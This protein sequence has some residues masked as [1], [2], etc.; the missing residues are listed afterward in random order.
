MDIL[1]SDDPQF[2][3]V[4]YK[5]LSDNVREWQQEIS[6]IV[7]ERLP[8]SLDL[9]T[10]VVFQNV[11]DE[12]GYAQGTAV[13]TDPATGQSIG[14]PLVV[15]SWHLAP[16]DLFIKDKKVFPLTDT[17]LAKAMFQ[18]S[19]GAGLA[20]QKPPP[21]MADDVFSDARN[22]PL[23]GKYSYSAPF[24]MLKHIEG[25]LGAEDI[26]LLKE[27]VAK[28]PGLL[29]SYHRR[30]TFDV[31][32]KYAAAQPNDQDRI[33]RDRT[34]ALFTVKKDGP[35]AYRLYSAPDEVYDPV[36]V[37]TDRQGLKDLLDMRKSELWDTQVDPLANLD[38]YGHFTL[39]PPKPVY[40]LPV[41]GPSGN[42]VD[43]SGSYGADL[44]PHRN[45]W[46][47]DPLQDDRVVREIGSFGRY[48]VRDRDGVLAK[49][50]VVPNVVNFDGKPLP[51]KLFLGKALAAIQGR[52]AGIPLPDD[53]DVNLEED[54]PDTGKIGTLVYREG[55]RVLATAPFQVTSVTVYK[56]L[57][58]LGVVD[59]KGNPANLIMSPNVD[60]VVK[61]TDQNPELGPLMGPKSNYL[62]SA[63]LR[64]IRM[65]RLCPV[66]ESAEDFKKVILEHM[67]QNPVKVAAS[68][69]K[70][71]FRNSQIAKYAK[72]TQGVRK[73]A[74]AGGV[75]KAA[76]DFNAL[77]RVEAEFLLRSWGLEQEKTAA[78]L[79]GVKDRIFL[80]VHGLRMPPLPGVVKTASPAFKK[81][82]TSIKSPI[83]DVVKIAASI[84]DAQ[85]VDSILGLGFVNEQNTS[86]FASAVPMLWE[87]VHMLAKLLLASRLG[88]DDI[89]E[90][91]ARSALEHLQRIIDGLK[92]LQMK[93][94][95][96]KQAS[97]TRS[98]ARTSHLGG[99][100]MGGLSPVGVAR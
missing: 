47:F 57:K 23:G 89:P 31:L 11:D 8:D 3:R 60:G 12:K 30:G 48:A 34:M 18:G 27:A 26:R 97:V 65:P 51:T 81:F 86:R 49:G 95:Q 52:V 22:P 1:F 41:D 94:S 92:R 64:F 82:V 7:A 14:I 13:A 78:L 24:S 35:D 98:K 80:E 32:N 75:R 37:A 96:E 73:H 53:A 44:G 16:L 83:E 39:E 25:T 29:A 19:M 62:V 21:N 99:R 91:S 33:N 84:E 90:E 2:R 77:D 71:V 42:G 40:G 85:T 45:P 46:V 4:Q 20:T 67:D 61:L 43:G 15:K 100:I 76:F 58:S 55:D 72:A 36:M 88:Y 50:W 66:S 69:G 54:R 9:S 93:S 28:N 38:Q 6:A 70:Y 79:D 59:Y 5:K 87:S 74:S 56:N 63:K 17:N 10:E 68:N